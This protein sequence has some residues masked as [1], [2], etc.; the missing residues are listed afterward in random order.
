MLH[1]LLVFTEQLFAPCFDKSIYTFARKQAFF[2]KK[3]YKTN[4]ICSYFRI[5]FFA[6]FKNKV[7]INRYL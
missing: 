3:L 7:L 5:V 2:V 1:D 4:N 6:I